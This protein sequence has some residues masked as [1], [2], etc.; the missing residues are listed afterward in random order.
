MIRVTLPKKVHSENEEEILINKDH[1]VYVEKNY[2]KD[3]NHNSKI[4]MSN[5]NNRLTKETLEEIEG[6]INLSK[7]R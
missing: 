7:R 4:T 2:N 5:G 3:Y 6:L 1:I